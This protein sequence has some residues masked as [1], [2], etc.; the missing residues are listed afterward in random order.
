MQIVFGAAQ[1]TRWS[2]EVYPVYPYSAWRTP[3]PMVVGRES[4]STNNSWTVTVGANFQIVWSGS[5]S[6][7]SYCC[8]M[9][10]LQKEQGPPDL[11]HVILEDRDGW[12]DG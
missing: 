6:P 1:D 12:M 10:T 8:C 9:S 2:V 11:P 7:S 3:L 5:W 4:V